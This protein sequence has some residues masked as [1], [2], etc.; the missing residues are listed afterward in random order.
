VAPIAEWRDGHTKGGDPDAEAERSPL[1]QYSPAI[2]DKWHY[3]F[4]I[5]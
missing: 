1:I 5:I 3:W 4:G 2:R